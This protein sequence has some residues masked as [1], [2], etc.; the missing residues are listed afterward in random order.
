MFRTV[1]RF[2]SAAFRPLGALMLLVC[3]L[4][5]SSD[6][7]ALETVFHPALTEARAELAVA[8]G[9]A[10][11]TALRRI[12][13]TW[14]RAHPS[15]VEEALLAAERDP[16]L[17]PPARVYAGLLAAYAR[18]RRGDLAAAR[19][20]VRALGYVDRWLLVG[21]FDNEGK[22]GYDA[23]VGPELEL[24]QPLVPGRAY[25]G[26]EGPIRWRTVPPRF[27]Y[28][29]LDSSA[30]VRPEQH[31]CVFA[32]TLV[33]A[34]EG[35]PAPRTISAWLGVSG[36][37]KLFW[38]GELALEDDAYR[39]H[40]ADRFAAQ[41]R[42]EPGWN[43]LTLKV[44][45]TESAP[46]WSLRFG[47]ARGGVEDR[48][49]LSDAATAAAEA[50]TRLAARKPSQGRAPAARLQGPI[51]AFERSTAT[52]KPRPEDLQA[53]AEYL[54]I[55]G[56]DDTSTHKARDLARR[57]AEAA[58]TLERLLLAGRLAED[59]NRWAEWL[60]QAS[61]LAAKRRL[62][63]VEL[64]ASQA[65]HARGGPDPRRAIPYYDRIL[66]LDPDH[67]GALRG[68]VELY[69]EAGLQQ[70]A[71]VTLE[72]AV[73][74]NPHSVYLL[75]MFASELR[76]LG[77]T[78]EAA[79]VER[80]YTAYRFDDRS[81]L[82]GMIDL[83][84]RRRDL[85]DAERWIERLLT[86]D[87]DSLWS[88]GVAARA[89]R[90]LG[91][92]ER[93]VATYERGL[94]LAP[95]DVA[96]LR[97][98]ADLKG[99]LGQREQQLALLQQVL[100]IRPQ[101]RDVRD[102]VEHMEKPRPRPDEAHAWAP[103]KFL[104]LRHA[105]AAGQNRRTLRDLQ[106]TTVFENG[107][108]SQFR[109]VVFQPLTAAA[110]AMAR[111]YAFQYQ[112]DRQ[113]VQLR[114]ARVFRADGRVDEAIEYGEAA[115]DDPS[116]A[117][118]TSARNFYVQL[119]RLEPGD[120]VE[121]RYRIDDTTPRN[122][123]A[124]YFGEVV[125][126]QSSEPVA[127]AEYVLIT[128]KS[129]KFHIDTNVAGLERSVSERGHQRVYRFFA[130]KVAPVLPEPSM[131]PWPEVLGFV[132]VSTYGSWQDMARWYWGLVKDQLDLDDETRKLAREITKGAK[133]DLDKVRA[134]YGWVVNNT[135][136]VAL[137]LGIYGYKPRRCV[138]TVARGWGDCKDKATV[139]VTL[140]EE[141]GIDAN[142][143]I[144]RTQHRG[145][146]RSKVASLAP[147]DHAIAYVPSLDLYLDGTAEYTGSLE[148]PRADLGAL[149]LHVGEDL[150]KLVYL[151][152]ADPAKNVLKRVVEARLAPNG[153][154]ELALSY[155]AQGASAPDWRRRYHASA[156]QKERVLSDLAGEFPGFTL[157]PGA[158]A[159][160][161]GD[162]RDFEQPAQIDVRGRVPGFAQRDGDR[163]AMNVTTNVRLTPNYA[164]LSSRQ[165]DLRLGGI[166]SVDDTFVIQLPPGMKVH[167]APPAVRAENEFG[168]Y[169][170]EVETRAGTVVVKSRLALKVSRVDN[171]RYPAFREF[172]A[173]ADAAFSRRLVVGP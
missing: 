155:V 154:A 172:C 97:L 18:S 17:A 162:L 73:E 12:W 59:R 15:H 55:T 153:D 40:D 128:P 74:R 123:F 173:A 23:E 115:A 43:D 113:S 76:A 32:K 142:L 9:P 100:K 30:L 34:A 7:H 104:P 143:V 62:T 3:A 51:Q 145:D 103:E 65:A 163:L 167:S 120:V 6:A 130:E 84:V 114:G 132:H 170:V 127:N 156:T 140:L 37:F 168:R 96:T 81:Y 144:V 135:R 64:L 106:V 137:E 4:L 83:A 70:T 14:D 63:S 85:R 35:S 45:G 102:Y 61:A 109:Q 90:A 47:D 58:P 159:L 71:L 101:E 54:D 87:P 165:Q 5:A 92:P 25:S 95:D 157:A 52:A 79:E 98:L 8:R 53:Y 72:R 119:P 121:L 2:F 107:L 69:N 93:A 21:P 60:E 124:D 148:L 110:A 28:G 67:L 31:V 75:N 164:S 108:S 10:T 151:P 138:Q 66:A 91:Q 88:Y 48:L 131:P 150:A 80:R 13:G 166:A 38:N 50:A 39:G 86:V 78:T 94:E 139:I 118:Y 133:T 42:L 171:A 33:R 126:L 111:Q 99:E 41:L 27:P 24:D 44:C 20:K 169:S 129:R 158:D 134:V 36:A 46:V 29:W 22:A 82:D 68:R 149:G 89:Y 146:F 16:R 160:R 1:V 11:Y 56:G 161:T 136:Y 141:L 105:K 122:E 57:A 49:E 19:S 116:I 125:Y 77:R 26:K 147:F 152:E 112:A 117:M